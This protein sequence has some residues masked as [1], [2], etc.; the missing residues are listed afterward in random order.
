MKRLCG[1]PRVT[2]TY[3]FNAISIN[4]SFVPK[5]QTLLEVGGLW[6]VKAELDHEVIGEVWRD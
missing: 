2:S 6:E 5:Y 3:N 1:A 4:E